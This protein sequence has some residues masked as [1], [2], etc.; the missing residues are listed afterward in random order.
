MGCNDKK[1]KLDVWSGAAQITYSLLS[2]L[3]VLLL[4]IWKSVKDS[5]L[6]LGLRVA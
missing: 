2:L 1:P 3:S 6:C 5:D 4:V